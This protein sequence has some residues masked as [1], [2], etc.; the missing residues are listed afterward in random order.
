M[1][2]NYCLLEQVRHE[3]QEADLLLFRRRGILGRLIATAGRSVYSHAAMLACWETEWFVLEVTGLYG[4]RA[5]SLQ[6]YVRRVPGRIDVFRTNPNDRFGNFDRHGAVVKMRELLGCEY[7]Y[8][9]LLHAALLHLPVVRLFVRPE[10][11]DQT[12]SKRPPFCSQA[13]AMACRLG[14]GIDPVPH[15]AD[16]LTEPA[17][18]AR[19]P[20]FQYMFTLL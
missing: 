11:N 7:G 14:G 3:L 8:L 19:T 1:N 6:R 20:F 16:R 5:V 9:G 12:I 10:L 4:G 17:D 2:V 13:V 18:L 15:L